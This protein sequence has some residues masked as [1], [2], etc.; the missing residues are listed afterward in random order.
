MRIL[1]ELAAPGVQDASKAGQIGTQQ[2]GIER[3]L[4]EG[5]RRGLKQGLIAG[6]LVGAEKAAERLGHGEGEQEVRHGQLA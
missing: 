6:A 4:L 2:A 1:L 3:Q 5:L